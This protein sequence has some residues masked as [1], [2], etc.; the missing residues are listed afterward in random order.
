[1]KVKVTTVVEHVMTFSDADVAHLTKTLDEL[2]V[3]IE[4]GKPVDVGNAED[5]AR[6]VRLHSLYLEKG[7]K[8]LIEQVTAEVVVD[9]LDLDVEDGEC[10]SV[11]STSEVI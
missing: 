1:M 7:F 4:A 5:N 3:L 11:K 6:A 9:D 2:T 10:I 8:A